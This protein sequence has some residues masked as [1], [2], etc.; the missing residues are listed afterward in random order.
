MTTSYPSKY[1]K[2]DVV[3]ARGETWR[4]IDPSDDEAKQVWAV[5]TTDPDR[6]AILRFLEIQDSE[7]PNR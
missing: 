1:R 4:V 5:S 6:D 2:G 7:D 3:R